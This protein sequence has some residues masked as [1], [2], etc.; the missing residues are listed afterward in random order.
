M[1]SPR[2]IAELHTRLWSNC[3]E[4]TEHVLWQRPFPTVNAIGFLALHLVDTR[5]FTL[6][7]LGTPAPNPFATLLADAR[8]MDDLREHPDAVALRQAWAAVSERLAARLGALG[9]DDLAGPVEQRFPIADRSL[10][11]ALSFLLSHEAYHVG[12][13]ALLRR[14]FGLA[15]MRY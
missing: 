4:G 12:Q 8:S 13:M 9:P 14:A 10:A 3:L 15:A 7:L 1:Q 5:H 2:A 6:D 11:G